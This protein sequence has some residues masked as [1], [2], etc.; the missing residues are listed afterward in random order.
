MIIIILVANVIGLI[1]LA[2]SPSWTSIDNDYS[3]GAGFADINNDG[4]LDFCTSNGNDMALN[5]QGVYMNINGVLETS[6]SWRS[7][8]SGMFGHLYL[9]DVNNDNRIDMAVAFLGPQGD[10]R[11]RIYYNLGTTLGTLPGWIS[12]DTDSSFDCCLGDFDL[13]GDLDLAVSA[14]DAYTNMKSPVKIYR[15]I[16]GILDSIPYWVALDSTPSD[17]VRFCDINNDGYLDLIVGYRR[18]LAVYYNYNGTIEN[19]PSWQIN[20]NSWVLRLATADFDNDGWRDLAV[21]G[22]GQLS[23]DTSWIKVFKN[24][25]GF[26]ANSALYTFNRRRRYNSC[27][28]WA[29]FN[30]DGYLDLAAGGWWEA[31][32]VFEN[33][34]GT[35]DTLPDWSWS[36]GYNLVCEALVAGDV[37]NRYVRV[38]SDTFISNGTRRLFY[39]KKIPIH[40]LIRVYHNNAVLTP[41]YFAYDPQA[42]WISINRNLNAGDT[43]IIEYKYSLYPD[44]A[45]SNW[46]YSAGN[47]LFYNTT[48]L[49]TI[50]EVSFDDN[51]ERYISPNPFTNQVL[52]NLPFITE[53]TIYHPSGRKIKTITTAPY[54]WDGKD[55]KNRTLPAGVYFVRIKANDK[56]KATKIVK[57]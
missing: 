6:A 13:D 14:G 24:N 51:I 33:T 52:F 15:N 37:R 38:L 56:I 42:G 39:V 32:V 3:T 54:L 35:F 2:S 10:C 21:A 8:D 7:S 18:K 57:L 16:G 46:S 26:F 29:D 5:K 25:N 12:A 40:Q 49:M 45:V 30:N 9:G 36:G 4:Y 27:V 44:L 34:N 22:N 55:S 50:N 20:F 28:L 11:T 23:G 43:I 48:P 53:I 19:I 31:V 47:Y 1:P 17:A 41:A